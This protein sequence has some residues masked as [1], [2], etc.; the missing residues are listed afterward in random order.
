MTKDDES[1]LP[2]AITFRDGQAGIIDWPAD[3]TDEEREAAWTAIGTAL[4]TGKD[5][6]AKAKLCDHTVSVSTR[7]V[8]DGNGYSITAQV[9]IEIGRLTLTY[10]DAGGGPLAAIDSNSDS[11]RARRIITLLFAA[12]AEI[13][14]RNRKEVEEG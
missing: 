2:M 4:G 8:D 14:P 10:Q 5:K 12:L 6:D 11:D 7:A 3:A 1:R 9:F 13:V